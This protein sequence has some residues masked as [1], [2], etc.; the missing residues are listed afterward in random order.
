MPGSGDKDFEEM[1]LLWFPALYLQDQ[2]L[3]GVR[4]HS[5]QFHVLFWGKGQSVTQAQTWHKPTTAC[6]EFAS[7]ILPFAQGVPGDTVSL[8]PR[9]AGLLSWWWSE[10]SQCY[11]S[12]PFRQLCKYFWV[13]GPH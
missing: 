10:A 13:S 5:L 2:G 3:K 7:Q 4:A 9:W 8:L 6:F 12:L 1:V 11:F